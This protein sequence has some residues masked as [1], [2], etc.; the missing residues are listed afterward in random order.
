MQISKFEKDPGVN[1]FKGLAENPC[2]REFPNVGVG[3]RSFIIHHPSIERPRDLVTDTK[4]K[5]K[6]ER[7]GERNNR[8]DEGIWVRSQRRG[9]EEEEEEGYE[10]KRGELEK[11]KRKKKMRM[12]SRN[13]FVIKLDV[14]ST[15][16]S[17]PQNLFFQKEH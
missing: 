6:S 3:G 12:M 15:H 4:R 1:C 2:G 7:K 5:K 17:I 11:K 16:A 9:G 14:H 8:K 13:N 10:E